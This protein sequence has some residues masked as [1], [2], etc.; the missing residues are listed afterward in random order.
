[1]ATYGTAPDM[2]IATWG[3]GAFVYKHDSGQD[4][5]YS[6]FY[7]MYWATGQSNAGSL[8]GAPYG[9]EIRWENNQNVIYANTGNPTNSDTPAYFTS[10]GITS[11]AVSQ[12]LGTAPHTVSIYASDGSFEGSFV[13][14]AQNYWSASTGTE[15][16]GTGSTTPAGT[17]Q[18]SQST[19]IFNVLSTSPSSSGVITYEILRDGVLQLTVPHTHGTTTTLSSSFATGL[20]VLRLVSTTGLTQSQ[21]LASFGSSNQK[22]RVHCNFW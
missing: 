21:T 14:A 11:G 8:V 15:G 16:T 1:M 13:V 9:I 10:G 12:V 2:A 3:G 17:I 5:T 20:W 7:E 19:L 4:T 22:R 18:Q 6:R